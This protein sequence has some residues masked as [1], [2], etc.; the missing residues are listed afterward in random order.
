M[1]GDPSL[2]DFDSDG[3]ITREELVRRT[4]EY[5]RDRR[6]R[7]RPSSLGGIEDILPLLRP[8][9]EPGAPNVADGPSPSAD[10]ADAPA[11]VGALPDVFRYDPRRD[12]KFAARLPKGVPDW[13][14]DRDT[15]GDGQLTMAEFAPKGSRAELARFARYDTDHNGLVTAAE[16]LR[17]AK[18]AAKASP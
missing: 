11:E 10:A 4:A 5:G 18:A 8:S 1:G 2:V 12:R 15:D 14:V 16:Y 3:Q 17:A 9:T 7:P 6:I 13:F